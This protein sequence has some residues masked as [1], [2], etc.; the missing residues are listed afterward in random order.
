MP[1]SSYWLISQEARLT[2]SDYFRFPTRRFT[3]RVMRG[4]CLVPPVYCLLDLITG[5]MVDSP[6]LLV[7]NQ[8]ER[9]AI[10]TT[11]PAASCL[12]H[13]TLSAGR[14]RS[15]PPPVPT[16]A[17]ERRRKVTLPAPTCE[18]R[19]AD[20]ERIVFLREKPSAYLLRS[21][22]RGPAGHIRGRAVKK[23][24]REGQQRRLRGES[25]SPRTTRVL[26]SLGTH[27]AQKLPGLAKVLDD[28]GVS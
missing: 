12:A 25:G 24:G 2:T 8:Q 26:G 27:V 21:G 13:R 23:T 10:T 9:E 15:S 18:R 19:C 22:S 3:F 6:R 14:M 5:P 4:M 20:A 1:G 16:L 7:G 28:A 11:S 17:A